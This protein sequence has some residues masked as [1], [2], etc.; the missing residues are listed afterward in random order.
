MDST[1]PSQVSIQAVEVSWIA[2]PMETSFW[3]DLYFLSPQMSYH[4]H[5]ILGEGPRAAK[6]SK[7][8]THTRILVRYPYREVEV[9]SVK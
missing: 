3:P 6:R 5:K 1:F 2:V 4:D 8:K 7:R 9:L